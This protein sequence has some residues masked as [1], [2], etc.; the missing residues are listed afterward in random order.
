MSSESIQELKDK[1]QS[2]GISTNTPGLKGDQRKQELLNRLEEYEMKLESLNNSGNNN[3]D[4]KD[5]GRKDRG[6]SERPAFGSRQNNNSGPNSNSSSSWKSNRTNTN[7]SRSPRDPSSSSSSSSSKFPSS[8]SSSGSWTKNSSSK[9]PWRKTETVGDG[10]SSH[11]KDTETS[12]E[13]DRSSDSQA[14]NE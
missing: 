9:S 8:S 3:N 1:L 5:S 2:L 6:G 14:D 13:G 4:E 7:D 10:H 12:K 11:S